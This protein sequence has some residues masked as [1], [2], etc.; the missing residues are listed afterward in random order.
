MDTHPAP[1]LL[2]PKETSEFRLCPSVCRSVM[3]E[4][5]DGRGRPNAKQSPEAYKSP[6]GCRLDRCHRRLERLMNHSLK[7]TMQE[8]V[9]TLEPDLW[10]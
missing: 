9:H 6:S 1:G 4:T 8:Q 5:S 10:C 2:L 3:L 7:H